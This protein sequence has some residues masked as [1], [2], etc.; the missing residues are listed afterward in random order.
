MIGIVFVWVVLSWILIHIMSVLGIFLAIAYPIWWLFFPNQTVCFLCR[1]KKEGEY[2]PFCKEILTKEEGILPKTLLSAVDNGLLILAFSLVSLGLVF[3]ESKILYNMGFPPTPKT[4]S[5]II[6]T[7]GQYRLGEI[8]PMKIEI[9]G[10]KTPINAVQ[11]DLGFDPAKLEALDISTEESFANVFI[12]KEINN[13]GGYARLTGGLPNPG[14]FS[15]KGVF[16]TVLFKGK[17]PG[18][19]K[20]GFLPTSMVL[21][22][23]S[24]GTNV[25][26]ELSSVSY[27]ILAEK[28][29]PEEEKMQEQ[30]HLQ[31]VVLGESTDNTQIKFFEENQVLGA[32]VGQEIQAEKKF[33]LFKV[34]FDILEKIDRFLLERYYKLIETI[35]N[36]N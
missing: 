23:D 19:V 20:I 16:G 29:S 5:F 18:L 2:C 15:E 33:N 35:F 7:K 28:I 22:N 1:T 6:P 17:A 26:K 4:V 25:L 8:F 21:A 31:T 34:V 10:I 32:K 14:Y 11:A 36:F 9:A 30:I 12:Q 3:G 27:L 24:R 13:E